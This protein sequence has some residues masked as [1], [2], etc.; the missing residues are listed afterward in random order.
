MAIQEKELEMQAERKERERERSILYGAL[1]QHVAERLVRGETVTDNYENASVLFLDIAGFTRIASHVPPGHV[2]HLLGVIFDACDQIARRHD[3]LKVKTIGDSY[4]AV[5]GLPDYV[6]DHANKMARAAV[7]I[8]EALSTL[9]VTMPPELGDSSWTRGIGEIHARV[10]V[11]CGPVVAGVVGTDRLQYDV[12]GDTVNVA[13]RMESTGEPGR[14]QISEDFAALLNPH[15]WKLEPRIAQE[16][17]GK[18]MM[19]T[20][21]LERV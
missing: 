20:Y 2:V 15:Q 12:W 21:W 1:P 11:H 3:L 4:M 19:R 9:R 7:E 8:Q 5:S 17:K 16:I 6:P 18:G 14:V 13:S 10:G